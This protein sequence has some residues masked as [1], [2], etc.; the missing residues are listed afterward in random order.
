MSKCKALYNASCQALNLPCEILGAMITRYGSQ[1]SWNAL[2][3]DLSVDH[4]KTVS[5]YVGLLV[6]MD[7]AFVQ[8]AIRE[9]KLTA[10]PKKA[11][12]IMFAD[13]FIFH[14]INAWLHPVE[15]PFS[16]QL[17][18]ALAQSDWASKLTEACATT[19][20]RRIFPTYYIK[21]AGEVDIAYVHENRLWPV[22]IKWTR[23]LR[24][25]QLKQIAK[26]PNGRILTRSPIKGEINGVPTEPLPLALLRLNASKGC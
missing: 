19:L 5:D 13:P 15:D 4:P 7:A 23:Q 6:S 11:K 26:Y 21:A 24:P 12:K 10:A 17:Q 20:F 2:A 3:S 14:A 25:K 16:E 18:P 22:E 8:H 9:D 1:V